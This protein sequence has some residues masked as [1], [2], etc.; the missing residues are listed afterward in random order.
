MINRASTRSTAAWEVGDAHGTCQRDSVG[1]QS[2]TMA[3]SDED[4]GEVHA[5]PLASP[6]S[7]VT[8]GST[9]W[10]GNKLEL[11]GF[12]LAGHSRLQPTA[13]C[14]VAGPGRTGLPD[15]IG[16]PGTFHLTLDAICL[17]IGHGL[18]AKLTVY[19]NNKRRPS[20]PSSRNTPMR[21]NASRPSSRRLAMGRPSTSRYRS[22][23]A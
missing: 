19:S 2:W 6:N 1:V 8:P 13:R 7:S 4:A 11:T 21:G 22:W 20:S 15:R 5:R 3:M 16:D 23:T 12:S 10:S 17:S 9:L 14:D 18:T